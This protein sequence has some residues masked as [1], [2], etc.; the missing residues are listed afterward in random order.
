VTD[1]NSEQ[2]YGEKIQRGWQEE[3]ATLA[4]ENERLKRAMAEARECIM[5][6]MRVD[7]AADEGAGRPTSVSFHL[8]SALAAIERATHPP[9]TKPEGEDA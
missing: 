1:W 9:D 8:V 7:A 3:R 2:G 5:R 4:R 6:K